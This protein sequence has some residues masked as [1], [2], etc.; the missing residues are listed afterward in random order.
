MS[1]QRKFMD[2]AGKQLKLKDM[3]DWYQVSCEVHIK[4]K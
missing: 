3:S 4:I 2:W 1:N